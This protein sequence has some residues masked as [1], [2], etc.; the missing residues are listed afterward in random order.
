MNSKFKFSLICIIV[1]SF[2]FL[3]GLTF[4]QSLPVINLEK[5]RR[6]DLKIGYGQSKLIKLA[7]NPSTGFR[8]EL[9]FNNANT[10]HCLLIQEESFEQIDSPKVI[11]VG[12]Y[13]VWSIKSNC[14][15]D[16]KSIVRFE[17]LRS[18]EKAQP[19]ASWAELEIL[20]HK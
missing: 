20:I 13:Q 3:I 7:S 6:I 5:D 9:K 11:G 18:W 2:N 15:Q 8:W 16:L 10:N 17:Y 1:L 14:R 4:S 12:G 19:P